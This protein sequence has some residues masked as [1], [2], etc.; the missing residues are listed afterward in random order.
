MRETWVQSLGRE[1]PLEK[2]MATHSS[3]FAWKIPWMEE[4]DRLS[5]MGSQSWT[6]LSDFT[7]LHVTSKTWIYSFMYIF[8]FSSV[9]SLSRVR[10]FVTPC[11]PDLPVHHQLLEFTQTHIHRV[12]D[13]IQPSNPLSSPSSPA[14]NPSQNQSLLLLF[15]LIRG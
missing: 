11:T 2:E 12:S 14:P 13:A 8:W 9:Q 10:L 1:D 7:S 3:T 4:P 6:L 5:S 15:I